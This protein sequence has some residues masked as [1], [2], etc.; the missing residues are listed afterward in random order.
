M[1]L[2]MQVRKKK[3]IQ[4]RIEKKKKK[5]KKK[6]NK[7]KKKKKKSAFSSSRIEHASLVDYG[8]G[9]NLMLAH[10]MKWLQYVHAL[11]FHAIAKEP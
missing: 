11:A 2:Q 4:S 1:R 10:I 5:K 6:K 9:W 3:E 8:C 7:K